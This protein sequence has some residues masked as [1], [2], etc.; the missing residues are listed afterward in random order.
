[1]GCAWRSSHA[2]KTDQLLKRRASDQTYIYNSRSAHDFLF[3]FNFVHHFVHIL[4]T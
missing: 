2:T 1:M 4:K 3:L